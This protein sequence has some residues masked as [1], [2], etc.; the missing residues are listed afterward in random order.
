MLITNMAS[1][2]N[3][4]ASGGIP[5]ATLAAAATPHISFA[6]GQLWRYSIET[7]DVGG[8][9]YVWSRPRGGGSHVLELESGSVFVV[10]QVRPG[11]NLVAAEQLSIEILTRGK[12]GWIWLVRDN[13]VNRR[14]RLLSHVIEMEPIEPE[15]DGKP[16]I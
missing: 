1:P 8:P 9:I 14:F 6:S 3:S 2:K 11:D 7:G 13:V 12:V 10:L 16:V 4:A 15:V 5:N